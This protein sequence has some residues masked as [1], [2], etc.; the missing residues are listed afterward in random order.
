VNDIDKFTKHGN[1][2]CR[3]TSL[4]GKKVVY[5]KA[6]MEIYPLGSATD[7]GDLPTHVKCHNPIWKTPEQV[8]LD[9]SVNG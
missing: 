7:E 5:T 3:F 8:R 9:I 1:F 6:R 4:D 2:S